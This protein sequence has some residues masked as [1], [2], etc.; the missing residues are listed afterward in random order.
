MAALAAAEAP[1]QVGAMRLSHQQWKL[2]CSSRRNGSRNGSSKNRS[3]RSS[4]S[5][6]RDSCRSSHRGERS[7]QQ[8]PCWL[9]ASGQQQQPPEATH[10]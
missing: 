9:L 10:A 4:S 8:L 7:G 5:N 1:V 2:T 3:S 6:S